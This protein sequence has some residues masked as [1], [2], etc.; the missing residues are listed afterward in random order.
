MLE[1]IWSDVRYRVRST[2][3][4][5]EMDAELE[6]ELAFHMEREIEK[7]IR[8]GVSAEAAAREARL[9]FGGV[10]R[11]KDDTRDARGTRWLDAMRQDVRYAARQLMH[12]R[13]FSL[14]V[15]ATMA[16]GIGAN[17]AVFPTIDRVLLRPPDGVV[18]PDE[19]MRLYRH[20]APTER[21]PA[22]VLTG[23][24]YPAVQNIQA[25]LPADAR[26]M[27]YMNTHY[28]LGRGENAP[29]AGTTVFGPSYFQMLGVRA[30][31]GR[32]PSPEEERF[33]GALPVALIS[34]RE[35][36]KKYGGD[37]SVI[38]RKIELKYK[39]YTIIG[40]LQS[41]FHGLDVSAS[42]YWIPLGERFSYGDTPWYQA[43][44]VYGTNVIVRAPVEEHARIAEMASR[45]VTRGAPEWA[46]QMTVSGGSII[47]AYGPQEQRP[48]LGVATRLAAVAIILL[49]I[50]WANTA[51]LN[52]ARV[53][54]RRREI[55]V[56]LAL[57][58]S[59]AR[60]LVLLITETVLLS[61]A[62]ALASMI[63]AA[64][65][66]GWLRGA[67][68]PD[69][70]WP[71]SAL[72]LRVGLFTLGVALF[73]GLA[74]GLPACFRAGRFG[75][76]K[77][78]KAGVREGADHRARL[79]NSLVALQAG[80]SVM[81]LVA[82]GTFVQSLGA[83]VNTHT[84]YD[85]SRIAIIRLKYDDWEDHTKDGKMLMPRVRE[86]L[87]S[88]PDAE[89]VAATNYKPFEENAFRGLYD[90]A[91]TEIPFPKETPT[92]QAVSSNFF[93]A[94]GIRLL[95][96]R[97]FSADDR[98]PSH[99][100]IIVNELMARQIWPGTSPIGQC[101]RYE[102]TGPCSTVIGVVETAHRDRLIEP[103]PHAH[104]FRALAQSPGEYAAVLII[105]A[106][107][108]TLESVI[109]N[110]QQRMR[111]ILPS[112]VFPDIQTLMD[113]FQPELRPWQLG[114]QLFSGLG[115]LALL[116][117]VVGMYSTVA[118]SVDQR[119]HEMGLRL[120]LG[121]RATQLVG[122]IVGGSIRVVIVGV[123][124]GIAGT[125]I[126][127]RFIEALLYNATPRDP[128]LLLGVATV[129]IAAAIAAACAPALRATRVDPASALKV[130]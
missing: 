68:F 62:A 36:L 66:G 121:A 71:G 73:T 37:S 118:Y 28:P 3:R 80:L 127:G 18:K 38:G 44:N 128:R 54:R 14:V 101:L 112:H 111:A 119:T 104:Y 93:Q 52:L 116:L 83:A 98:D 35:W 60:L 78:L 1:R 69:V 124:L 10:E 4:R 77:A 85:A 70:V 7:R 95:A 57:G 30:E 100:L 92:Y 55:A 43:W 108:G 6:E 64:W 120:A 74:T 22:F 113:A 39:P 17:A 51:N 42:D 47:A 123:I 99:P 97:S 33:D 87:E 13:R 46:G 67:L 89:M 130:E 53:A 5:S 40:V 27:T 81:L 129:L 122:L 126:A 103:E 32:L 84:G 61:V 91:G 16:L 2:V 102:P 23:F 9:A 88:L 117:A 58:I 48:E 75:L 34:H 21:S 79:R 49:I 41:N 94:T 24:Q 26:L 12:D 115:A 65:A 45:V 96:G 25:V 31:L 114:A 90:E 15:I 110:A 19:L 11:I 29:Q 109:A 105:R 72:D 125:L 8:S 56:R 63:V 82:A 59:R 20:T 86:Q 76:A 107:P 50:A 106:R